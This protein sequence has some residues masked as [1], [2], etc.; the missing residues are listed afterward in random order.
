MAAFKKALFAAAAPASALPTNI[1]GVIIDPDSRFDFTSTS[2]NFAQTFTGSLA[3]GDLVLGGY[4]RID[5]LNFTDRDTFCPG[6]ELTFVAGGYAQNAR[7]L[8]RILLGG[9]SLAAAS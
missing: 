6:C 5:F 2:G 7:V 4:G 3:G 9:T 1:H 8:R